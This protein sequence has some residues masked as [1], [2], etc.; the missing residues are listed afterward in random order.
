MS[1]AKYT[2]L[3]EVA[4]I[5]KARELLTKF[6]NLRFDPDCKDLIYGE[7]EATKDRLHNYMVDPGGLIDR[8]K[9]ASTLIHSILKIQPFTGV[10]PQKGYDLRFATAEYMPNELWA[11][12]CAISVVYSFV[13][14]LARRENSG[15]VEML[16]TRFPVYP[17]CN[18]DSYPVH[19]FRSLYHARISQKFD[20]F[21]FSHV[22]FFVENYTLLHLKNALL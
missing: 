8:H 5:P 13:V 21:S 7:Y 11:W 2:Q 1:P 3:W 17:P 15:S 20:M 14:E 22:L 4:F 12:H 9:I 10:T 6:P 18:H 19:V 16:K